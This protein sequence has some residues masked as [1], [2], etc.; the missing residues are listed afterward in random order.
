MLKSGLSPVRE[1][2][3]REDPD[4]GVCGLGSR[5]ITIMVTILLRDGTLM[6]KTYLYLEKGEEAGLSSYVC[7]VRVLTKRAINKLHPHHMD[8][9]AGARQLHTVTSVVNYSFLR[10]L[11]KKKNCPSCY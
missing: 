4:L 7:A 8:M 6:I 1:T 11:P 5:V 2:S 10:H 3:V 9:H